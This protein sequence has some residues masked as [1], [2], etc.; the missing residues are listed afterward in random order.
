MT[1]E[2]ITENVTQILKALKAEYDPEWVIFKAES[3]YEELD[4]FV[5]VKKKMEKDGGKI[6]YGW[7]IWEHKY[8]I[9]AEFHAVWQDDNEDLIDLTPK[10]NSAQK[11]LFLPDDRI[12]YDGKQIKNFRLNT[13][14]NPLV[15]DLI[16]VC[17]AYFKIVNTGKLAFEHGN[18][19]DQL[20]HAQN[21][22]ITYLDLAKN[23]VLS[24][25]QEDGSVDD[26]CK[27]SS[28]K[29]FKNCH[30]KDL[31]KKFK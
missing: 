29:K 6:V 4:C 5:N 7:T 18:I 21:E 30:G 15:N 2:T 20:S 9:E 1:P 19:T 27:C 22:K 31:K 16:T 25:L 23:I 10:S 11:I 13:S 24:L 14:G 8:F 26:L 3:G 28:G 17:D 12:R